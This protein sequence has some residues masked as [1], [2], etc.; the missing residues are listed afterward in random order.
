MSG[1]AGGVTINK[2][3]LKATIRDY[4]ENVLKPLNLDKS[5]NIT[6]VRRRPEKNVFG[7][8]DIVI[9]FPGGDKKDLKQEFAKHLSQINKIPTIPHKKNLKYFIHGS[10][11]TTLY[12]IIGKEGQYVQIDNI[13]TASEDEGKFTYSMLDLPAQEQGLALGLAKTVFTEL[14]DNQIKQLFK[15]LNIPQDSETPNEGE[16]YDFNLNT[17]ELSLRIVP[18]GQNGGREIW[19][20]T[21]FSDIKIVLKSLGVDIE[22]DKFEDMIQVIKNFKNRRSIERLK[23]MFTRNIRVGDAEVGRDKGIAK[24]KSI[25][26]VS[27]LEEKYNPL[28]MSLITPLI[29]EME[30]KS[31]IAIFPG[32][33][34][35]P[36]K[37][38][39]ARIQAASKSVGPLGTVKVLISPKSSNPN[40]NQ[41]TISA[42]QSLAIFNLYKNKG[43]LPDNVEFQISP[44]P[45]PVLSAYKEFETNK[46][47]SPE[48]QQPYI[49]VFGKE[50]A[51]RFA[52]ISKI[53]NITINDFPEAN[54]GDESAT[55]IR[56][57][58]KNGEDISKFLP[59]GINSE[60][61]NQAL[62]ITSL[63]ELVT[64]SEIDDVERIAD[65]WFEEY[66][67]DIKFTRH[68]LERINDA[69]NGKP[70]S[71]E[72]LE[73]I[74]TKTADKY[75][76]KLA[77]LPD[78]FQ[79]VLHSLRTDIN[80][81]FVLNYDEKNDEMDLVAKTIMRKRNFQTS[82]PK[83][84]LQE[85]YAESSEP[86]YPKLIKSITEYMVNQ[87]MELK[88]LPK[89]R[90]VKDDIENARDFFGKTA[91]YDPNQRIIVLYTMNRHPKDVMRS[92][93]HEMIHH[94]Q[95]C[96][97]RLDDIATDNTN[98][99]GALPE[100]EREAY[101]KGNMTFRNWEDSI[102]N[103]SIYVNESEKHN[104]PKLFHHRLHESIS[105]LNLSG[106]NVGNINGDS[107]GGEFNIGDMIYV[108][109][110]V[111]IKNPYND[112]G[113]FYSIEFYP[114]GNKTDE[115]TGNIS[116]GDYVRILNTMYKIIKDFINEYNPEYVG[117]SSM[118]NDYSK[119]YHNIYANLVKNNNIPGYFKKDNNLLFTDKDSNK[120]RI[121]VLKKSKS[122][123][124]EGRYDKI[125][126]DISSAIFNHWKQDYKNKADASRFDQTFETDDLSIDV[127]A[128]LE[129]TP[130][131]GKLVVNG[132]ADSE[133]EYIEVRFEIDPEKLPEFWE[134]I[135]MNL[136]DVI[137]HEIEH[138]T[139]GE[140]P[141]VIGGNWDEDPKLRRPSKQ[142]DDDQLIRDLID[143]KMLPDAEYFKLEKEVD[144]NL[145]GMY[146]RAKKEKRPFKDII[147]NYLDSQDITPNQKKE[148][149]D[150]WRTR[151][152]ALSLP[153]F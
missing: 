14:N 142:M 113:L 19:K 5:Y 13:I 75:G 98:E 81:P 12:P 8:I 62:N 99:D 109:N 100:I 77:N 133:D 94:M 136:K 68:F 147:N 61:Y 130:G 25:D 144:A 21:K 11:V 24:Q 126:N 104:Y 2:E 16:E 72:E 10:I 30:D 84:T 9:S 29:L 119:N 78:D 74:F 31:S 107:L 51:S 39:L 85:I 123:L 134:E 106:D 69:R 6:G 122:N 120:G 135:S 59:K 90:F 48:E 152:K 71:A 87:G 150:L 26:T 102:K 37:D 64:Q 54:V 110:I 18:I 73:N 63:N 47:K 103:P 121:I 114:K 38:H 139:H 50:E 44:D 43:L 70:I 149:I 148:I 116:G 91:F 60:E 86:D 15:D 153:K 7:D 141:N 127:D 53:P 22:K 112:K 95:N 56:I 76:K 57:A 79:A 65:E 42:D 20:S 137:R 40:P 33:F 105:E 34:K 146:F 45:S 83:L 145:Q 93:A 92:F 52:G 124:T 32:K 151:S 97:N 17:S 28:V 66:G 41:E 4:R 138:L 36:H 58:L 108:Y 55:N 89:V 49:A 1:A 80:L 143:A 27:S 23:G 82:N 118:D 125:T 96:E 46:E 101:E 115:P 3:D 128:N 131:T 111:K 129:F 67:I 117:I 132:G 88:P 35:P 140:G